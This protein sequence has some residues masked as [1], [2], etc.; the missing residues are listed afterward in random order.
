M[1]NIEK[2][3]HA[4][5]TFWETTCVPLALMTEDTTT[6]CVPRYEYGKEKG[7]W[8][9]VQNAAERLATRGRLSIRTQNPDTGEYFLI[10]MFVETKEQA[11][12]II[13]LL[14]EIV[15]YKRSPNYGAAYRCG[16]WAMAYPDRF[17][18]AM[19]SK[20]ENIPSAPA[21]IDALVKWV[22]ERIDAP[23][24]TAGTIPLYGSIIASRDRNWWITLTEIQSLTGAEYD[25]E[26]EPMPPLWA[27][28]INMT[29]EPDSADTFASIGDV[30]VVQRNGIT[31]ISGAAKSGKTLLVSSMIA[32]IIGR[33][34]TL[35]ITPGREARLLWADTEQSENDIAVVRKRIEAM[36]GKR[37]SDASINGIHLRPFGPEQST[38]LIEDKLKQLLPDVLLVD[39]PGDLCEDTNDIAAS[40]ATVKTLL[41]WADEYN[42][43]V[44]AVVHTNPNSDK[45]R[46]HLGSEI[47]RK[48]AFSLQTLKN[49]SDFENPTFRVK[50]GFMRGKRFMP[51]DFRY[52]ENG[53]PELVENAAKSKKT[54]AEKII[55]ALEPGAEYSYQDLLDKAEWAFVEEKAAKSAI[56]NLIRH[57]KIINLP[58]GSYSLQVG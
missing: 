20:I 44:V 10:P 3:L 2:E 46:G 47:E 40:Q 31:L 56:N 19:W 53:M 6:V 58:S 15:V 17:M 33:E 29:K 39:G 34:T 37:M 28:E 38:L 1:A 27:S 49:E 5:R 21:M 41:R 36:A 52:N 48:C 4:L 50:P 35:G 14:P 43:A 57:K 18:V 25:T 23:V 30:P 7:N 51:Y 9:K 22:S 16:Y 24:S 55:E 8:D 11:E 32:S 13:D 12:K 26:E 54:P 45:T 42:C